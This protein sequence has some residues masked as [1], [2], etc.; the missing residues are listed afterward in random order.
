MHLNSLLAVALTQLVQAQFPPPR[1]GV[2]YVQSKHH[3]NITIS[4]K[5]PHICET[6]PGVKQYSGYLHLP[7]NS[8]NETGESQNFPINS[9]SR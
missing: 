1:E 4:Y 8:V 3:E 7:P 5:N 9:E 6:T 2:K